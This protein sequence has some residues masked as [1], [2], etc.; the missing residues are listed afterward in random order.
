[1]TPNIKRVIIFGS[2]GAIGRGLVDVLV[3]QQPT[4]E[5]FAATRG[6]KSDLFK[7]FPTVKIIQADPNDKDAVMDASAD[8]DIIY[9]CI[10]FTRYEAKYWAK[11]WPLVVDNLIAASNQREGQKL[12]FCDNLY[13]YGAQC[14]ISPK[15]DTVAP[16]TSSKPAV[17]ALIR[18]KFQKQMNDAPNSIVVVGAAD[19]FGPRVTNLSFLGDTF[20][21][22]ILEGK[23]APIAIG[24]ATKIHDFCFTNDCSNAL[25]VASVNDSANGKF[26]VCPHAIKNK[27]I[28][29]VADD[30]ARLSGSKN[31]KVSAYPGWSIRL[32]SPFISFMSE[33]VEMLPFWSQDY[34]VDDSDF[35][36]TFGVQ[37][38][39]YE[40]ALQEYIEFYK[41]LQK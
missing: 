1:M 16:G 13:A 24:S 21:K 5:I 4:W 34:S 29:D 35:C 22:A 28:Q 41:G 18:Q 2:T 17:R 38:T 15:S 20:T 25:Y 8:K 33:M 3:K 6:T 26:W 12:V 23:P 30:V 39:P 32:L 14:N 37:P 19:F 31:S 9:S 11:N 36:T 10:G 40:Q 27:T 7:S